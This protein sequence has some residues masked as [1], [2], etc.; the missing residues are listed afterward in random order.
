MPLATVTDLGNLKKKL[1]KPTYEYTWV[2]IFKSFKWG[3]FQ[4]KK[5]HIDQIIASAFYHD[6]C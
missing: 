5:I 4:K 3:Y 6:P 2:S 1:R